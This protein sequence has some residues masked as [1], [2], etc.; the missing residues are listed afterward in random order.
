MKKPHYAWAICFACALLLFCIWGICATSFPVFNPYLMKAANLTNTEIALIPTVRMIFIC[1]GLTVC[2][3]IHMKLGLRISGFLALAGCTA[4][5]LI[6]AFSTSMWLYYL[7]SAVIGF[8]YSLG[9]LMLVSLVLPRWFHSHMPLAM[10][11][12]SSSSGFAAVIFPPILTP[13]MN[14]YSVREGLLIQAGI[15]AV[16]AVL[17][18][19]IMRDHPRDLGMKP[20]SDEENEKK[21]KNRKSAG[22]HSKRAVMLAVVAYGFFS[23]VACVGCNQMSMLFATKG[24]SSIEIARLLSIYGAVLTGSKVLYGKLEDVFGNRY[25]G[26]SAFVI[27]VLGTVML[28]FSGSRPFGYAGVILFALGL[29]LSTIGIPLFAEDLCPPG[30]Y[31]R[32]NRTMNMTMFVCG[33]I[34][35]PL[36]G[37]LADFTGSYVPSYSIFAAGAA[38]SF[39]L[40]GTAYF[41]RP[42]S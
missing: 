41:T 13:I 6:F 18:L 24:Y 10:G 17:V 27:E 32:A 40:I 30:E 34:I 20:F 37:M 2:H 36:S 28:C 12:C 42:K 3:H 4:G 22:V 29:P 35:A 14:R 39:V 31:E 38:V 11:I 16:C 23:G 8:S 21:K 33:L 19:L 7:A 26:L 9:S 15:V 25:V 1:I 5:L